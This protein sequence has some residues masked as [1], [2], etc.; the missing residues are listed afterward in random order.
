L[1][2]EAGYRGYFTT[3]DNLCRT[4]VRASIERNLSSKMKSFTAPTVLVIDDVGLLPLGGTEA[5]AVFFQVVNTRYEKGHPTIV[6]TNRGLPDWGTIFGDA[7]V[8]AAV[9]DRLMHNAIV[10]NIKGPS[11]RLREHNGLEIATTNSTGRS[12]PLTSSTADRNTDPM[13]DFDDR[14]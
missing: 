10:F 14:R 5:S 7:V 4:R 8:A 13:S 6:T 2:V 3:A 1:A 12:P 11:W 9:L